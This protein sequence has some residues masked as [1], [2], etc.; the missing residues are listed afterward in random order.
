M[1][2][3]FIR[4]PREKQ[5]DYRVGF[6]TNIQ[7]SGI[8]LRVEFAKFIEEHGHWVILR[9]FDR[10]RHSRFWDETTKT[11]I[12]GPAWEYTD[13]LIRAS[14]SVRR[15]SEADEYNFRPGT[16]DLPADTYYVSYEFDPTLV[17]VLIEISPCDG[18]RPE[19]FTIK[20]A[21][22]IYRVDPMRDAQ[23]RVEY[24]MLTLENMSPRGDE[25]L[26]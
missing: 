26:K 24:Y 3:W 15:A 2:N 1:F 21:R 7:P 8:D 9:K 20:Q 11:A 10:S 25:S 19:T 16:V 6:T 5:S 13:Y 23:G 14:K 4:N 12:G 18:S 17:D 22:D